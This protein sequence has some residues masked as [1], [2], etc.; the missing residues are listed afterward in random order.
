MVASNHPEKPFLTR[1]IALATE[2]AERQ[3]DL[4][5]VYEEAKE[6]EGVGKEG[7]KVIKR[8]VRLAMEDADKKRA[9]RTLE[10]TAQNLIDSLG[11]L[12]STP[13]GEA[14]IRDAAK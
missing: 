3:D 9:R 14:A 13:L 7:V 6:A 12:A 1:A 5:A 4:K 11:L 2:I 8:A 10:N